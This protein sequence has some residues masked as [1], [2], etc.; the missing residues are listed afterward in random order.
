[1]HGAQDALR[2]QQFMSSRAHDVIHALTVAQ[3]GWEEFRTSCEDAL[4]DARQLW[5]KSESLV[6]QAAAVEADVD[7]GDTVLLME[8]QKLLEAC[9]RRI[10]VEE[11][12]LELNDLSA[13][14][15]VFAH[16][17]GRLLW[18]C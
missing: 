8:C 11:E 15:Y 12:I 13:E 3:V 16:E 7:G 5:T 2:E 10:A 17:G 1:M 4:D 18:Q 9:D 14:A 6:I